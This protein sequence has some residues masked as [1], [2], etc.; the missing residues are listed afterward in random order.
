MNYKVFGTIITMNKEFEEK[1]KELQKGYLNK[2]KENMQGFK[3]LL[4]E[5]PFNFQEIY[6]RV[7]TISGTS[8]MYEMPDLS[9]ISIEFEIYIKPI[10]ENP[11]SADIEE[12]KT[13]FS[14][15]LDSIEK[16]LVGEQDGQSGISR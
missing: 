5:T 15:Y 16:L 4:H 8:G 10:K 11:D 7:H 12:F 6:S 3:A 13:R 14:N 2:L 9:N 1:F